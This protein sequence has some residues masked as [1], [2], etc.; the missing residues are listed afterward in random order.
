MMQDHQIFDY[1]LFFSSFNRV[2][3]DDDDEFDIS[4]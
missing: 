4:E 2:Q 3:Y 1:F